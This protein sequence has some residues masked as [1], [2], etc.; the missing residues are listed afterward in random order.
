[1]VQKGSRLLKITMDIS[2]ILLY[3]NL[4]LI[5]KV[6]RVHHYWNLG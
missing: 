2:E 6:K 4:N 1:M 3:L 5:K